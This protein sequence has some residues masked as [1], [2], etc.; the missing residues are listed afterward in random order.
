[1]TLLE[2]IG[3]E[4]GFLL[5]GSRPQRN[6]NP[7]DLE[8]GRFAKAHGATSSDGRFAEFPTI[9]AGYAALAD[10]LAE[11]YKGLTIQ[12]MVEKYAPSNEN[13]VQSYVHHLCE[14]T[15]LTPDTVID[16]HIS[17]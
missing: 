10:L 1:M 11:H 16:S 15:G 12:Q 4:E 14:W 17:S 3:R 9:Q 2:A 5:E 7:G 13:D 6:N 8:F